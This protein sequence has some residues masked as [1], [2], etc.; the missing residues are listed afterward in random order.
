ME[1]LIQPTYNGSGAGR[2]AGRCEWIWIGVASRTPI[3]PCL[4]VKLDFPHHLLM[5][6]L[7]PEGLGHITEG[8]GYIITFG[9][10][11]KQI[12]DLGAPWGESIYLLLRHVV[13]LLYR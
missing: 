1:S 3:L 12:P 6:P 13:C 8:P 7:C 4:L 5:G 2:R 11:L 10:S 9:I